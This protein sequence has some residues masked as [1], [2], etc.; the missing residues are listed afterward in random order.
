MPDGKTKCLI[1]HREF[2]ANSTAKA[3]ARR[4][5]RNVHSNMAPS[6]CIICKTVFKNEEKYHAHLKKDH[7]VS[8]K[9]VKEAKTIQLTSQDFLMEISPKHVVRINKNHQIAQKKF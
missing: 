5:Y 3:N 8:I 4:H 7:N 1:C 2:A 6:P 9:Q